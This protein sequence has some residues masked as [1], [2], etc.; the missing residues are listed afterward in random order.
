MCGILLCI[1]S[2]IFEPPKGFLEVR[3]MYRYPASLSNYARYIIIARI[4]A[5]ASVCYTIALTF[6]YS[7]V[8]EKI[9]MGNRYSRKET[10]FNHR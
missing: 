6:L 7:K 5:C 3:K 2:F 1:T 8:Y 10:A 9:E 4:I